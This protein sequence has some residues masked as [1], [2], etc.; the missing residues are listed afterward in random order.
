MKIKSAEKS[1]KSC[2]KL[3][4]NEPSAMAEELKHEM[5]T[6]LSFHEM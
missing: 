2:E 4:V 1:N 5:N 6:A 3:N